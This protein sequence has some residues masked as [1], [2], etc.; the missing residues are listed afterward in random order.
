MWHVKSMAALE[1]KGVQYMK[2]KLNKIL[3]KRQIKYIDI[4]KKKKIFNTKGFTITFY[5]ISYF[6]I[7]A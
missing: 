7:V 5:D 1:N 2:H 6:E 4:T 3:N